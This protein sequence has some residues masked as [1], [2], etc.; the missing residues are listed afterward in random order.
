[1]ST[2]I[3]REGVV[4]VE[5]PGEPE[6]SEE[7]ESVTRLVQD[8]D[9]CD[10]VVDFGAVTILTSMSLAALLRLRDLQN[11][12]GRRLLLCGVDS[13]TRGIFSITSLDTVFEIVRDRIEAF[14][15]AQAGSAACATEE[16][17]IYRRAWR[18]DRG[19]PGR[20]FGIKRL[21]GPRMPKSAGKV[22]DI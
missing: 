12:R 21:Q 3:W 17:P 5:L 18:D 13:A 14:A 4:L 11:S 1:M 22:A 20:L 7:L 9:D 15:T 19:Y 16:R 8:G 2:Q 10:V 6:T